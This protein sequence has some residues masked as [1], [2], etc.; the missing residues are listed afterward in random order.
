MEKLV[1]VFDRPLNPA[2]DTQGCVDLVARAIAPH[3]HA[4]T[5]HIRDQ[6]IVSE[7]VADAGYDAILAAALAVWVDRIELL[8]EFAHELSVL[9]TKYSIYSVVESVPREY[10]RV[11]WQ[12]GQPSPGVTLFALFT[13]RSTLTVDEFFARWLAH[14]RGSLAVHPLTRYHRNAV[15]RKVVGDGVQWDA[16]VEERVGTLADIQPER[17]YKDADAMSWAIADL[18][19]FV[20]VPNGGMR[21]AL[22]T[23]YI[24]K[25]PAWIL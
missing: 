17:F 9:G 21:C 1:I 16:I 8:D 25:K 13:R 3:C 23:E 11:D 5:L 19:G 15:L 18:L 4:A 6:A 12:A 7:L 14:A 20:D 24:V 10:A 2:L 22:L